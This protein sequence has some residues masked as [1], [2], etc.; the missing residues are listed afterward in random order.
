MLMRWVTAH[1]MRAIATC[2]VAALAVGSIVGGTLAARGSSFYI[3]R[4][5]ATPETEATGHEDSNE[6]SSVSA[7]SPDE[8]VGGVTVSSSDQTGVATSIVVDVGGAVARPGIV[9]LASGARVADAITA[10]G[11]LASDADTTAINQAALLSDGEKIY[12]PHEGEEASAATNPQGSATAS[13]AESASD[14]ININTATIEELDALPGV[15]PATAQA[16]VDEREA[17]G[18]FTS[19]E[20]IMRV[21][22]IGEKKYEKLADYI[23]V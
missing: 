3:E 11:G 13:S 15:G 17:N 19:P 7:E 18:S 22:G 16:I 4:A 6:D 14:L 23:C 8:D 10:A 12:I 21:S 1:P 5:A 20:D 9:S 2:I